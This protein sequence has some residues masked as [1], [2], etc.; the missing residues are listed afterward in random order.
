[1]VGTLGLTRNGWNGFLSPVS[2]LVTWAELSPGLPLELLTPLPPGVLTKKGNSGMVS[3]FWVRT[4]GVAVGGIAAG[5]AALEAA[6]VL[7]G[8]TVLEAVLEAAGVLAGVLLT[9][10]SSVWAASSL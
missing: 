10:N 4:V 1:V 3:G 9:D 6:G 2:A 8:V 5:A 7:A